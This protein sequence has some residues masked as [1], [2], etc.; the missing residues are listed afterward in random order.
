MKHKSWLIVLLLAPVL[1][2]EQ[3]QRADATSY[4]ITTIAS[5]PHQPTRVSTPSVN[6]SGTVAFR[7]ET[8]GTSRDIAVG[9][10]GPLTTLYAA[11]ADFFSFP[12]EPVINNNGIVAFLGISTTPPLYPYGVYTGDGGTP[13]LIADTTGNIWS[14][15]NGG[16]LDV[17]DSGTVAFRATLDNYTDVLLYTGNGGALTTI[18]DKIAEGFSEIDHTPAINSSGTVAFWGRTGSI[19]SNVDGIYTGNGG[20]FTLLSVSTHALLGLYITCQPD[21]NDS[22]TVAFV[23]WN[24]AGG[25]SIYTGDGSA[26]PQETVSTS[27]PFASFSSVAINNSGQVAFMARLDGAPSYAEGIYTGPD[28]AADKVIADDDPLDGGVVAAL[29]FYRGGLNDAGQIAFYA[30]T[31]HGDVYYQGVYLATPSP[32][33]VPAVTAFWVPAMALLLAA[34]GAAVILSRRA[35]GLA[36]GG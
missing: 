7:Y 25:I 26:D 13:T 24:S 23:A 36:G 32:E 4:T 12:E 2:P 16:Y 28:P 22:G 20:P 35:A 9:S 3:A 18:A 29:D 33:P 27:G 31:W 1:S 17:N 11:P 14:F 8:D 5:G 15:V 19:P 6:N 21:M 30:G 34:A 10:G